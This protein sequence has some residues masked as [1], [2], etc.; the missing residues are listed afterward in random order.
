MAKKKVK[1]KMKKEVKTTGGIVILLLL[2]GLFLLIVYNYF[3]YKQALKPVS[4]SKEYYNI[5]DFGYARLRSKTDY[6]NNG[7]D[8]Y[9]DFLEGE[10][11]Y[12]EFNPK[13][14][15]NYYDKGYPPVETEGVCTDV[16]WY[17][18]KNA[19]YNLKDML[20]YDV[21]STWGK[22]YYPYIGTQDTNIDFRRV[23]NQESFLKRY[24]E[25][26]ETDIYEI[27]S[28][29]PGDILVF[30]DGD[31]IAMVSDKY[32]KNGVP[33]LIQNRDETQKEKEEDRLEI[34]DMELTGHYRFT[35]NEKIEKLIRSLKA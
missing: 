23:G 18:L 17:A 14:K 7:K 19:G 3:L 26:L 4:N 15:S 6:N 33:F 11:K 22:G 20:D 31:H 30:D 28:F 5:S 9:T 10:K 1:L 34:T 16:I 24:A 12:A 32:N 21:K 8:D 25:K 13:Y 2:I 29:M 27:G 35:Y